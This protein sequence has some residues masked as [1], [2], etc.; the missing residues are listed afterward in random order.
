[1]EQISFNLDR[2]KVKKNLAAYEWQ[3]RA[4]KVCTDL[5]FPKNKC[6][7]VFKWFKTD[8]TRA[9]SAYRYITDRGNITTPWK[10]FI[11][12]MVH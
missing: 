8:R 9:E 12:L 7:Q 3:D 2:Y 5:G 1:M 4:A 11:W 10:Y 6:S